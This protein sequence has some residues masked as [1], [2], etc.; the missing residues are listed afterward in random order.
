[1]NEKFDNYLSKVK[2]WD[3][4][5]LCRFRC[6]D[7]KIP[8]A[9]QRKADSI[10][11]VLCSLCNSGDFADEFHLVMKRPYF[12][13]HSNSVFKRGPGGTGPTP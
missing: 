4:V 6:G 5:N 12:S 3:I 11:L 7:T 10:N 9:V 2:Y 1:M 8:S 13:P